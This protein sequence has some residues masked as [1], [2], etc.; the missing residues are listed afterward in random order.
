[1]TENTPSGNSASASRS[2]IINE[3]VGSVGLGFRMK[4]FPAAIANGNIHIGTITGKLKG[5]TPAA[6][7]N[8]CR[9]VQLSIPVEACAEYSPFSS[10]GMPHENS[11][12]SI[13]R[14]TSPQAS[15]NTLP[16]SEVIAAA[17]FSLSRLTNSRNLNITRARRTGGVFAHAGKAVLAA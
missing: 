4:Q 10:A 7:P 6:I 14:S 3:A 15:V 12:T 8:G 1:M 16:C 17:S 11:S 5:V 13:P 9:K 2:A